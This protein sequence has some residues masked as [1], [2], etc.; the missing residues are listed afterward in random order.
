MSEFDHNQDQDLLHYLEVL[1]YIT[2]TT[3]SIIEND[4][5]SR[6]REMT[7]F[8]HIWNIIL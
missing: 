6:V 7:F 5:T 3:L 8:C 2:C 1:D 4:L